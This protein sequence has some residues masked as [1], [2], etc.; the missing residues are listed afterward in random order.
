MSFGVEG[1]NDKP[2]AIPDT[3]RLNRGLA[4][5]T[6]LRQCPGPQALHLV[7]GSSDA[8]VAS[9]SPLDRED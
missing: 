1:L 5:F 7:G 6:A 8:L 3:S 4:G 2:L 9:S